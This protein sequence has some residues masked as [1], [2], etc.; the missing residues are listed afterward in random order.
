MSE[1]ADRP[2]DV[3]VF[4]ATSF[5]GQILCKYLVDRIGVEGSVSWAIAGRS[6]SKLE[7]VA[8]DTGAT[9]P[10]IVADAAD[11]TA[12]SSLVEST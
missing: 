2:Y 9:V 1:R 3:V 5:V 8:N 6:S 4:G 7:E 11:L 12:M 10:R